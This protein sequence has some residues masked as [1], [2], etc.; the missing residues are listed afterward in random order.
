MKQHY[1][2]DPLMNGGDCAMTGV[3]GSCTVMAALL[4]IAGVVYVAVNRN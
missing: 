4:A 1:Q 2:V 3:I